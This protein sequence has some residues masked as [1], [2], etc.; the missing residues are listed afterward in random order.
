MKK[1][2]DPITFDGYK[3]VTMAHIVPYF[4]EH[5]TKLSEVSREMLQRYIDEKAKNG[6]CDGKGGLS[7]KSL[8][9]HKLILHLICK[10][11]KDEKLIPENPCDGVKSPKLQLRKPTFY[12]AEQVVSLF[13]AVRDD[14]LYPLIYLTVIYGLRRSEVLGIQWNCI[15]WENGTLTIQHTVVAYGEI[16]RKDST[17]TSASHRSY[18]LTNNV[19]DILLKL[20][21]EEEENRR[22]FGRAYIDSDYVFHRANGELYRPDFITRSFGKLL[23]KNHL[24][25]IRFHDLRHSCAS[26]LIAQGYTLKDIQEWLGHADF[27]TTANLY[28]HLDTARKTRIAESMA[29]SFEY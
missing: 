17:K 19:K 3:N 28:A 15:N 25:P 20:R 16:V 6:R 14:P 1:R 2:I 11:A 24:P 23:K 5:K 13:D 4:T 18:P 21:E 27:A 7:P 10:S 9:S 26:L 12:T 8:K 22:L 29:A